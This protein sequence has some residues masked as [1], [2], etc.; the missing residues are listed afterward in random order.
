MTID[1]DL[2]LVR[3]GDKE[4]DYCNIVKHTQMIIFSFFYM[5]FLI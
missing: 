2:A 3:L 4:M 1:M 5:L